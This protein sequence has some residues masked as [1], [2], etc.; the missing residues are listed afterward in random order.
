MNSKC[1][2]FFYV[3]LALG[4]TLMIIIHLQLFLTN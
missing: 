2:E 3:W 4:H 1:Y